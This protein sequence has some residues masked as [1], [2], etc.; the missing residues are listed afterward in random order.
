MRVVL[1]CRPVLTLVPD[2]S[3]GSHSAQAVIDAGFHSSLPLVV[4]V[5]LGLVVE[6]IVHADAGLIVVIEIRRGSEVVVER[7][8]YGVVREHCLNNVVT[9]TCSDRAAVETRRRSRHKDRKSNRNSTN[10]LG[11]GGGG[12][13]VLDRVQ[14]LGQAKINARVAVVSWPRPSWRLNLKDM[15][16]DR[17]VISFKSEEEE[18]LVLQD[19]T[20]DG[21]IVLVFHIAGARST[22]NVALVVVG[23]HDATVVGLIQI[24]VEFVGSALGNR[25]DCAAASSA[26]LGVV[27]AGYHID[28]RDRVETGRHLPGSLTHGVEADLLCD[29]DAIDRE[30]LKLASRRGA[31]HHVGL[32]P[33][34][35]NFLELLRFD[36]LTAGSFRR[37]KL[38]R[39]GRHHHSLRGA[40][41]FQC[42]VL[43]E[44]L[45][46][47]QTH[48][49]LNGGLETLRRAGHRV[50]VREHIRNVVGTF[51]ARFGSVGRSATHADS[52]DRSVGDGGA[53]GVRHLPRKGGTE[54]LGMHHDT[55]QQDQSSHKHQA[56]PYRRGSKI[57]HYLLHLKPPISE[58]VYFRFLRSSVTCSSASCQDARLW[59]VRN[60]KSLARHAYRLLG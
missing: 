59:G 28:F 25:V 41:H 5:Q 19:R 38:R 53:R 52:R 1:S 56:A 9:A 50:G 14:R 13:G 49:V 34:E 33:V 54:F 6:V 17:F 51:L 12:H 58:S 48:F 26:V 47:E 42:E 37:L 7:S 35:R 4:A 11:A 31:N 36:D 46:R 22:S 60:P 30:L 29:V 23:V 2:V 15:R 27:V 45:R 40:A 55:R 57:S 18:E 32:V 24:A 44:A 10:G 3:V 39:R 8:R 16:G 43:A 20:A 21:S